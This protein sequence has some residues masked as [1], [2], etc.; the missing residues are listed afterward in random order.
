MGIINYSH[1]TWASS[2]SLHCPPSTLP[3]RMQMECLSGRA[4]DSLKLQVRER[5]LPMLC[6]PSASAFQLPYNF[7]L[8]WGQYLKEPVYEGV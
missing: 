5:L 3:L 4:E 7:H 6:S 8:F 1:S 2:A